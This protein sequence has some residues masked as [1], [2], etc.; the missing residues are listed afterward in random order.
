MVL[1]PSSHA[2][3]L[4]VIRTLEGTGVPILAVDFKPRA[5]GLYSR[6]V[7]PLLLPR[8]Y[9]DMET[10]A[11][12]MLALGR[13]FRTPPVL[14][15]VDDEDL[16]LSLK[17]QKEFGEVY[18]LPLSPWDITGKIVNKGSFYKILGENGFPIPW[19]VFVSSLEE[20]AARKGELEFPCILKPTYSTAFRQTFDV[21]AKRFDDFDSLYA[22]AGEVMDAGIEFLIQEFIPGG[23]ERLLTYVAYSGEGGEVIASFC[24]RKVHQFPP[25]FGTCR[26]GESIDHPELERLGRSLLKIFK[27]RGISLTEFKMDST[28]RL[29]AIELNPRPGDWPE[30]LAQLSGANVVLTAYRDTLGL[31]VRES[32]AFRFGLKWA[33]LSEDLYYC[34]RGYRLL[35][36]PGAHRGFWGWYRDLQGLATGAFFSWTDPL[37]GLVRTWGMIKDFRARERMIPR[38]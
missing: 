21:K 4:S 8:M 10:F 1:F 7:T 26:L 22:Y 15:C 14:F 30:R 27:Y 2:V 6:R 23:A 25:D 35:G 13:C 18:R 37:P 3:A 31:P 28:G 5:A 12:Y 20:L 16:F 38:K 29:K 24:G 9:D 17:R 36:Y 19:T 32:R 33:N 11:E 34:L